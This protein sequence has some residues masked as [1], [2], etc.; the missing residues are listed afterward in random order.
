MDVAIQA[1]DTKATLLASA[2]GIGISGK[3]DGKA[4][5][6]STSGL[7]MVTIKEDS[8]VLQKDSYQV[9]SN[10]PTKI[11]YMADLI[12]RGQNQKDFQW[13][14]PLTPWGSGF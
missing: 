2:I 5:N 14:P 4:A 7:Y 1:R 13:E 9:F 10:Y 8:S 6:M 12:Y 11:I 3:K